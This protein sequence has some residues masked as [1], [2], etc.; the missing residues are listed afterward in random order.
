[1][2]LPVIQEEEVVDHFVERVMESVGKEDPVQEIP[3]YKQKLP[4]FLRIF[5]RLL[6]TPWNILDIWMQKMAR[7]IVRPPHQWVGGCKKRGACCHYIL[8]EKKNSFYGRLYLFWHKEINGFYPRSKKT[9]GDEGR[10]YQVM[11][12]RY[13]KKNGQ[14]GRYRLR[15]L[16]CRKW[17]FL[18][19]FGKP[20]ILKGCGFKAILKK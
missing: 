6:V 4:D 13:L 12:C 20:E 2:P 7:K 8:I 5:V 18:H 1:M 19:P 15:P 11:G 16:V 9:L 10:E 3:V 14:C 17:P